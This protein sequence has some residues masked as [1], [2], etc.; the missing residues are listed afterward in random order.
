MVDKDR[1]RGQ[2]KVVKGDLKQTAGDA[3]GDPKL[4]EEGKR[5]KAEGRLDKIKGDLKDTA[6][7]LMP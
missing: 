1:I 3:T 6:R 7:N 4:R 2:A 5:D